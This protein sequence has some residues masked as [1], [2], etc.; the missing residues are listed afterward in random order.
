[1]D[2]Q[3]YTVLLV[4][5]IL[6]ITINMPLYAQ[7]TNADLDVALLKVVRSDNINLTVHSTI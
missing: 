3:Q 1:M 7:D 4:I 2:K 6:V 5:V